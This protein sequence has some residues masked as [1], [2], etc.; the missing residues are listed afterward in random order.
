MSAEFKEIVVPVDGSE[1][2]QRAVRFAERLAKSTGTG[3]KLV[4]VFQVPPTELVSVARL[5]KEDIEKAKQ[6]AAKVAFDK[7]HEAL[8]D[9]SVAV[10][11]DVLFG[12]PATE[13]IHYINAQPDSLVVMGRRGLTRMGSLLLGSVSEK[14]VHHAAGSVTIVH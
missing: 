14:V 5:S 6:S 12:D 4:Y 3:L 7:A 1:S 13:I 9:K 11:A 2:S 8:G 10:S